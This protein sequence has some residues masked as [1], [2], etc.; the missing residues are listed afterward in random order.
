MR[1]LIRPPFRMPLS[2]ATLRHHPHMV[3]T[4]HLVVS[5]GGQ[6]HCHAKMVRRHDWVVHRKVALQEAG[7][8]GGRKVDGILCIN[9]TCQL[10]WLVYQ[11]HSAHQKKNYFCVH[12][13]AAKKRR[14]RNK[15]IWS[16]CDNS[17]STGDCLVPRKAALTYVNN[18]PTPS[19]FSSLQAFPDYI[20]Y[21]MKLLPFNSCTKSVLKRC[22]LPVQMNIILMCIHFLHKWT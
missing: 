1:Q 15:P 8:G 6:Q 22:V 10:Y 11:K 18:K 16:L 7:G 9:V 12:S 5:S 19:L 2:H 13:T 20:I 3:M 4:P 17:W 14:W 21:I